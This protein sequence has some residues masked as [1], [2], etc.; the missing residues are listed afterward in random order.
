MALLTVQLID[1]RQNKLSDNN[2]H[3][4]VVA[5]HGDTVEELKWSKYM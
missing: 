4:Y 3:T 5:V 1:E 2:V